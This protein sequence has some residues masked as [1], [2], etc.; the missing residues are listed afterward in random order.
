M[1]TYQSLWYGSVGN[2]HAGRGAPPGGVLEQARETLL[3]ALADYATP[4]TVVD[5]GSGLGTYAVALRDLYP[6]VKLTL[7][8]FNTQATDLLK[9]QF[10]ESDV[11]WASIFNWK[12]LERP[13][14]VVS[15]GLL[16][17]IDPDLLPRAYDAIWEIDGRLTL[18]VD[19]HSDEPL[20]STS[21]NV[22][23]RDFAREFLDRLPGA[24]LVSSRPVFPALG[25]GGF[26]P[27]R[28]SLFERKEQDS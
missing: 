16:S 12:P 4:S 10:P 3:T 14:L 20:R 24:R 21:A 17:T 1:T 27:L 23:A 22:H 28:W 19:Y 26:A 9:E 5:L 18:I 15:Y 6:N 8:D 25:S 7:V 11:I 13:D 2:A